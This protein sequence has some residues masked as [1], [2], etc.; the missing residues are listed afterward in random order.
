[1]HVAAEALDA[2]DALEQA[3]AAERR[4][5][6]ENDAEALLISTAEKVAALRRAEALQPDAGIAG[7]VAALREANHANGVLLSRRRREV[8]WALRHLGRVE[9]TPVYTAAGQ[10][11][12]RPQARPLGVG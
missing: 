11:S 5:L 6:L 1:M 7:R 3:L 12:A 2:L 9:S 4:A 8:A 10:A